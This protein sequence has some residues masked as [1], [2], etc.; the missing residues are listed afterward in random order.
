MAIFTWEDVTPT[1]IPNT[2]MKKR[3]RDGVPIM[4][5]ITPNEGYVLHIKGRDVPIDDPD[6]HEEIGIA[7]GYN[8]GSCS[9]AITYDFTPL[10][11]TDEN[12]VQFTAYGAQQE[13]FTR[14]AS[15]VR[16]DQIYGVHIENEVM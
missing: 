6:T 4:Y 10:T 1:I 16:E 8:R 9:C 11:V 2:T 12:G 14:P 3:I 13:F 15:E 5:Q 7:L